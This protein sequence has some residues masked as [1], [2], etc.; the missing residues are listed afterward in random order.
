MGINRKQ[1]DKWIR[2]LKSGRYK[3]TIGTLQDEM[4]Y[5]CLGVACKVLIP[6]DK[7]IIREDSLGRKFMV[8]NLPSDQKYA[9]KWLKSVTNVD[10]EYKGKCLSEELTSLN[11]DMKFSFKEIAKALEETFPKR[12]HKKL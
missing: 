3:Q 10:I 12:K 5:C 4:G 11:D 9:P 8:G 7:L 6:K 2:A 1:F